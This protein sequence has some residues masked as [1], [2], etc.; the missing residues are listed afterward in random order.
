MVFLSVGPEDGLALNGINYLA[1]RDLVHGKMDKDVLIHVCAGTQHLVWGKRSLHT[2]DSAIITFVCL[3]ESLR[4]HD[5]KPGASWRSL[6]APKATVE[7]FPTYNVGF[8]SIFKEIPDDSKT[9][10][11]RR[12][13]KIH[14]KVIRETHYQ[15]T[16]GLLKDSLLIFY[17]SFC[18]FLIFCLCFIGHTHFYINYCWRTNYIQTW[19]L[20]KAIFAPGFSVQ[21]VSGSADS[22]TLSCSCDCS[23]AVP[24]LH[25]RTV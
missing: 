11:I 6:D 12:K 15:T 8:F 17:W 18:L 24:G 7:C 20:G 19:L 10:Y 2:K 5:S 4:S 3:F 21:L 22:L 13:K 25:V 16:D 1:W 14:R 9:L 23:Q